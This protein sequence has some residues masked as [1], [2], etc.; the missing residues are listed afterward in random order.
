MT[1]KIQ[2]LSCTSSDMQDQ[3]MIKIKKSIKLWELDAQGTPCIWTLIVED[4]Y[5]VHIFRP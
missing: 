1:I 3:T 5:N 2:I 4:T